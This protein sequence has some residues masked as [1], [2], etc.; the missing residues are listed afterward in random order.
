ML[1]HAN[2][3]DPK[4]KY[5]LSAPT[6]DPK[7]NPAQIRYSRKT[8]EQYVQSELDGKATGWRAFYDGSKWVEEGEVRDPSAPKKKAAKKKV[9]KKKVTKKTAAKKKTAATK[10]TAG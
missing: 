10:S 7:G 4:F 9:A 3:L 5:L 2:E 8:K 6:E 1:P